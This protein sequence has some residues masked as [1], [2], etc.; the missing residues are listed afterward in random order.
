MNDET[1]VIV[2]R[3]HSP[4]QEC[5]KDEENVWKE[6]GINYSFDKQSS[7][8]L[9]ILIGFLPWILII[10]IWVIIM[11]RMQGQ[12][13]G[14]RGIFSFGKSRAKM[15]TQEKTKVTFADVAGADEAK[16]E[17]QEIIEFLKKRV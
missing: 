1:P 8:W 10:A 4:V 17:L 13:G 5:I 2:T 6:N 3:D 7:E 14:T 16:Q 9:N 15:V 11:R 12:S